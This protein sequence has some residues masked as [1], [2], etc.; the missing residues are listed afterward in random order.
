MTAG[1][2][3]VSGS[4]EMPHRFEKMSCFYWREVSYSHW[5]DTCQTLTTSFP[6][7]WTNWMCF[8]EETLRPSSAFYFQ[9]LSFK[10]LLVRVYNATSSIP[11]WG[12][13]SEIPSLW[14][15]DVQQWRRKRQSDKTPSYSHSC[16][17]QMSCQK[18]VRGVLKT[19]QVII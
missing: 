13:R 19:S 15:H 10:Y 16:Q 3:W 11:Q 14:R 2:I 4:P 5:P 6:L 17:C 9:V 12:S 1:I 18:N 7:E 8:L